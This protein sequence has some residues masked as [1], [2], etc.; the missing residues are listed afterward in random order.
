MDEGAPPPREQLVPTFLTLSLTRLTP[1]FARPTQ[2]D[3]LS[4]QITSSVEAGAAFGL[5]CS[6]QE[7]GKA[8]AVD[9]AHVGR[10]PMD[11]YKVVAR[12]AS[13]L[14]V[15]CARPEAAL[16][17][18]ALHWSS[19]GRRSHLGRSRCRCALPCCLG[20]LSVCMCHFFTYVVD[21]TK[22]QLLKV[23]P[24]NRDFGVTWLLS[25][26]YIIFLFYKPRDRVKF[27]PWPYPDA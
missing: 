10:L 9:G 3:F 17:L 13:V 27:Y 14:R 4:G 26:T 20:T 21:N 18:H 15:V 11:T 8:L 2:L 22:A 19:S 23:K 1:R 12:P 6:G 5:L 24:Q 25:E 16:Q 7:G